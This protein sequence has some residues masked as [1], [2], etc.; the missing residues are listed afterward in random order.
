MDLRLGEHTA[1]IVGGAAG[2]GLATARLFA[3]EGACVAL[4]DLDP[5]VEEIARQIEAQYGVGTLG[6]TVDI[7][8]EDSVAQAKARTLDRFKTLQHVVHSAAISS[9][10]FGFPFTNLSADDWEKTIDVNILG[11]VRIATALAPE[12]IRCTPASC[13]FVGSVAGQVGSQ[14]DPPYSASKAAMINF[15]QCM[16][17]DLAPHG[18][19]VNCVSPGMVKTPLNASVWEAWHAQQPSELRLTY[20]EWSTRKIQQVVPLGRWQQ[21]ED[22]AAMVVFLSSPRSSE[23][24]GQT[25]NVDGG[26]VMHS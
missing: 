13:I 1:V 22:I 7:S 11:M 25:I 3:A 18:V 24:T 17:K 20:D 9:N 14:T 19:R 23:V 26:S 5:G 12:L 16:A 8:K 21:A 4:W 2:I 15:A 10:K 6:L